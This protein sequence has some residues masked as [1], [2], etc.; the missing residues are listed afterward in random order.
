VRRSLAVLLALVL[1]AGLGAAA[2]YYYK[3]HL[4]RNVRGSSSEFNPTETAPPA[5]APSP[6]QKIVWPMFGYDLERTHVGPEI[7][8]R[9]PFRR[10]W[11]AGGASLLEFPPAIG[12]NRLFLANGAG[13]LIAVSTKTGRRAWAY[14][15][16]RCQAASPALS[17]IDHGTVYEVFLNRKPCKS[18]KPGDGEVVAL[19]V[20]NGKLRWRR[21]IG[22]S[23]TSPVVVGRRLYVGD[24][25]GNVYALDAR[26]GRVLWR[27]NLRGAV[28]GGVAASGNRLYVGAYNG[29]VYALAAG[30]GRVVWRGA[31]DPRLI[32]N[33]QFYSTPAVAYGRVYIGSTDGKVY[34]FGATTGH[35]IWSH[36]TGGYVYG[37]PAVWQQLVLVGSYSRRFYAFDA[38][39]GDVRWSFTANG[40]ISG[41]ATVIDGVVYFATLT[42]HGQTYALSARTGKVLWTFHDGRYTPIAADRRHLYLLGYAKLYAFAPKR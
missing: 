10:L 38:E 22:A 16:H 11:T 3:R 8:V 32:G 4:E 30:S 23:E 31:G 37:S 2:A 17:H 19:A 9:P 40:P 7:A 5:P 18:P 1:L 24:W 14:H 6:K 26:T 34:S 15:A 12:W 36:G 41:S 13:D 35:R 20:G 25:L 42:K 28:K 27:T 21:H 29:H 33:S 39:T